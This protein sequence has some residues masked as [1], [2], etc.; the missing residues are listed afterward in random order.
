MMV[1]V[2]HRQPFRRFRDF[3]DTIEARVEN[4]EELGVG[5]FP[6]LRAHDPVIA[7][8]ERKIFF[9]FFVDHDRRRFPFTAQ[10]RRKGQRRADSVA[11]GID[12]RRDQQFFRRHQFFGGFL[13]SDVHSVSPPFFSASSFCTRSKSSW[14][15]A[16]YAI[17]SSSSNESSGV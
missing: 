6:F 1:D 13:H 2:Q 7:R 4:Y 11:V 8:K 3:A 17:V 14:I 10:E 16:L 9:F 15:C 12:V 5:L